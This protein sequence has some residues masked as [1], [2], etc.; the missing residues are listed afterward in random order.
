MERRSVRAHPRPDHVSIE[1]Y[2][3]LRHPDGR[4]ILNVPRDDRR[5]ATARETIT[6]RPT[7]KDGAFFFRRNTAESP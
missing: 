6:E 1:A 3:G 5:I 2:P 4:G 7:T